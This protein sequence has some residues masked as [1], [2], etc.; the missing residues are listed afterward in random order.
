MREKFINLSLNYEKNWFDF[1]KEKKI[2]N[3]FFDSWIGFENK[4]QRMEK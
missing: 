3:L 4:S 2:L 1:M